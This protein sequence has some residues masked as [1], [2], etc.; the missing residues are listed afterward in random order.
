[1][2]AGIEKGGHSLKKTAPFKVD[3]KMN[4][5]TLIRMGAG[6]GGGG[7]RTARGGGG[8]GGG[9]QGPGRQEPRH[10]PGARCANV[11]AL[12]RKVKLFHFS[13]GQGQHTHG[14]I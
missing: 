4:L 13:V 7:G 1:M 11:Q 3:P 2:L 9:V 12:L 14:A 6:G 8:R 5:L 10:L